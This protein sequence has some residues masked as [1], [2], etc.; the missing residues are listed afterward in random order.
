MQKFTEA[1]TKAREV[2]TLQQYDGNWQPFLRD[3]CKVSKLLDTTG[4]ASAHEKSLDSIRQRVAKSAKEAKTDSGAVIH[5]AALNAKS[6][7]SVA[8][9][10]ATLKFLMH[11]YR[12]HKFGGQTVWVYSPPKADTTWVFDEIAGDM[13]TMKARLKREEEIFSATERKWMSKALS[14]SRKISED[15]KVKLGGGKVKNMKASSK[16][17]VERWFLDQDSDAATLD[18]AVAKLHSGFKKI[19]AACTRNTLVF[20]DYP[21]WRAQRDKY[22]GAAFRG[23]EG[24]GFPVVYLEGAFTRLTGNSGQAWLCAETII[25]EFSHHEVSTE[26]HFYDSDGL[27]PDKAAFPYAK[28]IDNADSWGYFALDLAGYLSKATLAEVWK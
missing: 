11:V 22:F 12:V 10:A 18:D 24:G 1:Y 21:D 6:P 25:H 27:K 9:R 2:A 13:G 7:G 28:A 17:I 8:D 16:A 20:A 3:T 14:L 23:G 15:T 4:F 26:D 5:D 19:A